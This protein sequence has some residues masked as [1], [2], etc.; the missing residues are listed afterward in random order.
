MTEE[1]ALF[2]DRLE[3]LNSEPRARVPAGTQHTLKSVH[4][5]PRNTALGFASFRKEEGRGTMSCFLPLQSI[6]C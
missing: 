6:S 4:F 5:Q 2:R 3:L 1:A